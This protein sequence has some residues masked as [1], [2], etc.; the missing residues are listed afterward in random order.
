MCF[1]A[2]RLWALA[3]PAPPVS[4]WWMQRA[5]WWVCPRALP[6]ELGS[7]RCCQVRQPQGSLA[8]FSPEHSRPCS[9]V[10]DG[11]GETA[12]GSSREFSHKHALTFSGCV[13]MDTSLA[14]VPP[15]P[16]PPCRRMTG[17][18]FV[19]AS[20]SSKA[21]LHFDAAAMR[22]AATRHPAALAD[23]GSYSS[24]ACVPVVRSGRVVGVL[25]VGDP[26]G[27][28]HI[29]HQQVHPTCPSPL[30]A[31]ATFLGTITPSTPPPVSS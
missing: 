20:F 25:Q 4:R 26:A 6:V 22:E 19:G 2:P 28:L 1:P 8:D 14:Y 11:C 15:T 7:T 9:S 13:S 30:V 10:C 31:S 16:P 5:H 12:T 23:G 27:A 18:G 17:V 21:P 24:L 3:C 29:P